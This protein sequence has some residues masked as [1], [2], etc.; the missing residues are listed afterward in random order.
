MLKNV[1]DLYIVRSR[2]STDCEEISAVNFIFWFMLL[3]PSTKVRKS[4]S[5]CGHT[6]NISSIYLFH[7]VGFLGCSD[8]KF[9]SKSPM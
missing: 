5:E 2:K 1:G 6:R 8:R 4:V 3:R 9:S 7:S